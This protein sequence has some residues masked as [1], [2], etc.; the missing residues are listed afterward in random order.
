MCMRQNCSLRIWQV[1]FYVPAGNIHFF[2]ICFPLVVSLIGA[3]VEK[4]NK[5]KMISVV[6]VYS[7]VHTCC[8]IHDLSLQEVECE[9][10][11]RNAE[12]RDEV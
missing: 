11:R 9:R 2:V 5:I 8:V 10:R 4:V 7:N 1:V 12:T 6:K 3:I